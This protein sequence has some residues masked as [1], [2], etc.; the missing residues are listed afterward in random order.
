MGRVLGILDPADLS[1]DDR[2]AYQRVVEALQR[3]GL[4][5]LGQT[6]GEFPAEEQDL[7]RRAWAVPPPA[8]SDEAVDDLV[9]HLR[10]EAVLRRHREF[11]R[12]LT[13]AERRGD[14]ALA[15]ALEAQVRD[16]SEHIPETKVG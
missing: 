8:V 16:L 15:L 12:Q 1:E 9:H 10:R 6:L 5:A 14:R 4:D 11:Q 2:A 3:G 7:V 13:E